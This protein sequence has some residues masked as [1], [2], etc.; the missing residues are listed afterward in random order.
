MKF[1]DI[2]NFDFGHLTIKSRLKILNF[3]YKEF[4]QNFLVWIIL[5][6]KFINYKVI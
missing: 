3:K 4:K 2:Y 1:R 6:K 5:N